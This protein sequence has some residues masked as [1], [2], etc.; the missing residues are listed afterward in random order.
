MRLFIAINLSAEMKKALMSVKEQLIK[1]GV[2]GNFTKEENLHLTLAFIGEYD[3]IGAVLRAIRS[4]PFEPFSLSTDGLGSFGDLWW[5][6]LK[7]QSGLRTYVEALRRALGEAGIP[8]DSKR[9]SPHIT[10]VRRASKNVLPA[11]SVPKVTMTA[12]R[13]SL[14]RSERTPSGMVYTEIGYVNA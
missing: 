6:G 4:V 2:R 9:F 13:V 3:D 10:L 1:S 8:F 7:S 14:M 11:V 12:C 5:A